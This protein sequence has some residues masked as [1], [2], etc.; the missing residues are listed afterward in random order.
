M[1]HFPHYHLHGTGSSG[2]A[3]R[4]TDP[5]VGEALPEAADREGSLRRIR[6]LLAEAHRVDTRAHDLEAARQIDRILK[7]GGLDLHSPALLGAGID[8]EEIRALRVTRFG[9]RL[10][11]FVSAYVPV[12]T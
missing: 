1:T 9:E 10:N 11:D 12:L 8:P 4:F 5:S 6:E 3:E 7:A 2:L